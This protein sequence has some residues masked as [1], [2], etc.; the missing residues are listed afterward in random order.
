MMLLIDTHTH[1]YLPEFDAD[2]DEVIQRAVSKY[3]VKLLMPN[4]NVQTV[5]ALLSVANRY[6]GICLPMAGLHPTSV[7][8]DFQPQLDFIETLFSKHRFVAVGETGI[9]LYWD[10]T[11]LEEQ[12]ASFRQQVALAIKAELPVVIHSRESFPEVFRVL[13]EFKGEKLKGVFHAF[14]GTLNDAERAVNMGFKIGIGGVI[15]FKNSGLDKIVKEYGPDHIILETYSPYLSPVPF[16][17]RRNE[18][19]WLPLINIRLAEILG[20]SEE[21][22]ASKTFSNSFELFN[23]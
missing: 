15:T 20:M 16:R 11:F 12:I 1:V 6:P 13:D 10:K 23:L 14:S 2:R 21:Q 17:G 8:E 22:T 5:D 9:D 18:S 19:S 4:V 3:V 7:N